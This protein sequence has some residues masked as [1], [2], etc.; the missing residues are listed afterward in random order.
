[1]ETGLIAIG[2]EDVRRVLMAIGLA[3]GPG[4]ASRILGA[5]RSGLLNALVTDEE[6][7]ASRPSLSE[8]A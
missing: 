6:T 1:L 8:A 3:A 4:K 5:V 7:A 2:R